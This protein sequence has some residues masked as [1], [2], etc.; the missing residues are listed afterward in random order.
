MDRYPAHHADR[1][2]FV[3]DRRGVRPRHDPWTYQNL[4]VEDERTADGRIA[5]VAALFLTGRECPWRCVMCDLWR[6][7]TPGDTPPG[8][9]PAQ[10]AAAR[11]ALAAQPAVARIKLYNASNFFDPRAVPE[12]DYG[13]IAALLDGFERVIVESHPALVGRQADRF[14]DA[15]SRTP[16]APQLEVAM[17]LETVH[18]DALERLNKRMTVADFRRAAAALADRGLGLRVFLLIAPPF[19]P[20]DEQDAWLLRSLDVALSL[21]ASV[22]SLVPTRSGNGAVEALT[23]QGSFR[24]P[25]LADI[26]RSLASAVAAAAGRG[27]V[28]VDLWDLE[29]FVECR[30]CEAARRARLHAVNLSQ[31]NL[32]PVRCDQ[33]GAGNST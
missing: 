8:A 15:L 10:L 3:H 4:I 13:A 19:V 5:P 1:D 24:A 17:G 6:Y 20:P 27:S 31:S 32:P 28:F 22:T 14:L 21:G 7:T 23:G 11:Q 29:R 18:P 25:T 12:S 9:I 30:A 2:R 33:C 16:A 26:E